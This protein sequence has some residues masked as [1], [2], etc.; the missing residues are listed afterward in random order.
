MPRAMRFSVASASGFLRAKIDG[1]GSDQSMHSA[2]VR[3]GCSR[4]GPW[5]FSGQ[6]IASPSQRAMMK[7]R[8]LEVGAP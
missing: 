6:T 5:V 1:H 8:F 2:A 4:P 3:Y 7:R